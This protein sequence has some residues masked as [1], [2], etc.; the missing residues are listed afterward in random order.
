MMQNLFN[1]NIT[2]TDPD[3]LQFC[4]KISD[5]EFWYCEPNIYNEKCMP[6]SDASEVELFE[7]YKSNPKK[8]LQDAQTDEEVKALVNNRQLWLT[9]SSE[10]NDF[11]QA[12]QIELLD[13]YGYKWDDFKSD[14]ERNQII[15][16]NFSEQNP[17]DFRNDI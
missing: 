14:V 10:M 1:P 6:D 8:L 2:C 5:R 4:L 3:N 17:M 13:D 11:T 16:E 15:C 7:R 9:A 12:E